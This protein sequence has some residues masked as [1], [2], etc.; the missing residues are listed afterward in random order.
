MSEPSTLSVSVLIGHGVVVDRDLLRDLATAEFAAFGIDGVLREPDDFAAALAEA[1]G[2]I[3]A[4]PGPADRS[5]MTVP[6]DHTERTVWLDI[7]ATVPV[8]V[9]DGAE[10]HQGRGVWG[11]TWAVRR[12]VH[13]MRYPA[14]R[15]AYGPEPD[16]WG[17]LRLPDGVER[18][19]VAVLL[20][21]G[22][23]R[24]I[25]NADL[26]DALAVDLVARG[27]AT[28]NVEYRRPDRHGWSNTTADVAAGLAAVGTGE[29]AG[30]DTSRIVAFGHSA[31]SQLV[32][33]AAADAPE[34]VNLLVS[35]AGILDLEEG[36]R[37]RIGDGAVSAALGGGLSDVP[38]V[39]AAAD[40]M[41]RLPV[42]VPQVVVQ[43]RQDGPDLVDMSRRYVRA[44]MEAGD[45]VEL[46]EPPGN[47]FDVIDPGSVAWAQTMAAVERMLA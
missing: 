35:L 16:Q 46:L 6:G 15:I 29:L 13:R 34:T 36:T 26:M 27:F 3:V 42:G 37:R 30:L 23:W 40:P 2:A 11:I 9:T 7:T 21:G 24:S 20:H 32:V 4:L 39:Y 41:R 1:P 8:D 10:H 18:L 38:E 14:R 17:E 33:R 28:W 43:G 31:S 25:W 5:L 47:H 19:P 12:A 22:F 45:K 44:A